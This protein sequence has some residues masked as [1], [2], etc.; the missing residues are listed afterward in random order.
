MYL[1]LSREPSLASWIPEPGSPRGRTLASRSLCKFSKQHTHTHV[2]VY[3]DV[4]I[5]ICVCTYLYIYIFMYTCTC[6]YIGA[7]YMYIY[8]YI[9]IY[10]AFTFVSHIS[11]SFAPASV[12]RSGLLP[13][14]LHAFILP[15]LYQVFQT[16]D[17]HFDIRIGLCWHS[18]CGSEACSE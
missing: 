4:C 13:L 14:G 10:K 9:Y 6:T 8:I 3:N 11:D 5:C 17:V 7:S 15:T 16:L 2:C 1:E 18:F 12:K